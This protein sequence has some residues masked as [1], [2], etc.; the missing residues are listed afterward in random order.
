MQVTLNYGYWEFW[1]PYDP[2]NGYYGD[3]KCIFDGENKLIYINPNI[4]QINIKQDL[5]SNWKEWVQ[6][7]D[8]SK[9][10]PAIRSTGGDPVGS[11]VYT[12][13]VYFLIN[14]WRI[15]L[16]HAVDITGVLY[17]DNYSSPY[18]TSNNATLVNSTVS[19]LVQTVESASEQDLTGIPK[20]VWDYL[21]SEADTPG[22]VGERL[23]KLLTV[24]KYLGLK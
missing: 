7:R 11:G 19:N 16:D 2:A 14:N 9:F 3:Q 23:S 8:N 12:G 18:I 5:Y 22:S 10:L 20:T 6:V 13:D 17:S 24:A 4:S 21:L 15:F 1:A